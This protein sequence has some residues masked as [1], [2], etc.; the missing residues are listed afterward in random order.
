MRL[1]LPLFLA[2]LAA[3]LPACEPAPT[4]ARGD[5]AFE[6]SL[7]AAQE[8]EAEG[9]DYR[10]VLTGIEPDTLSGR[11]RFGPVIDGPTQR[12]LVVIRLDTGT[13][14]GG[15][16]FVTHGGERLPGPGTYPIGAPPPDSL[17]A[18]V[19]PTG[20]AIVYRRGLLFDLAST[21]GS[22][23]LTAVTDTLVSGTFT[24][25]LT[26]TVA[27]AGGRPQQGT[28]DAQGRFEAGGRGA[29]FI[30]GM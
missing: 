4:T 22:I 11:A 10:V 9:D 8:A 29:G 15:G 13:D 18:R 23:T 6:D 17:R 14:F 21:E 19:A 26:G 30:L 7:L 20:F 25:R 2:A 1:A 3:S 12:P 24:A 5:E 28:L 27:R 16:F